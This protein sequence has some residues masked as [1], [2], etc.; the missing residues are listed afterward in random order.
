MFFYHRFGMLSHSLRSIIHINVHALS[1]DFSGG[2]VMSNGNERTVQRGFAG[3]ESLA[4]DFA[5][6]AEATVP[7]QAK[8][9]A[10]VP[11]IKAAVGDVPSSTATQRP[12]AKPSPSTASPTHAR[13][14]E[15]ET[16]APESPALKFTVSVLLGVLSI[17]LFLLYDNQSS[18]HIS[19]PS[20]PVQVATSTPTYTS[21]PAPVPDIPSTEEFIRLCREG[22]LSEVKRAIEAGASVHA[23]DQ[24]YGGTALMWAA[25]RNTDPRVVSALIEAGASVNARDSNNGTALLW[26]AGL[27]KNP[28][29]VD[30]LLRAGADSSVR[31]D[32][33]DT[34]ETLMKARTVKEAQRLLNELGYKAGK[35]DG[36]AGSRTVR[37]VKAFQKGEKLSQTGKISDDLLRR[38]RSAK[39]DLDLLETSA[40]GGAAWAQ[41]SLGWRYYNGKGVSVNYSK[42]FQWFNKAAAQG[43]A[44]AQNFIGVMYDWGKGVPK[45]EQKAVEWYRKAVAQG[46]PYAQNNLGLCYE[47]GI[48][49]PQDRT[50]AIE[51]YRKAAA[52]GHSDGKKNLDRMLGK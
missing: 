42:A 19:S 16:L 25:G 17:I 39:S 35:V 32:S 10:P 44:D 41:Y 28:D 48:G 4:S 52:Q 11:A 9:S 21:T 12:S 8:P 6:R 50:R 34:L 23:R 36:K 38:L 13:S 40:A 7:A 45:N 31:D 3:L 20:A 24:R 5:G 33:G 29:V 37:A 30:V 47:Y 26:A 22:S 27:N 2:E 51:L 49:V 43:D 1:D 46:E 14:P 18:H 15:K